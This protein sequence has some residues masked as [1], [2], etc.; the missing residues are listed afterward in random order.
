[1]IRVRCDRISDTCGFGVPLYRFEGHRPQ[2]T[3]WAA[4]KGAKALAEYQR[5][6]NAASL[7]GLP[8]VSTEAAPGAEAQE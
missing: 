4:R 2:L 5:Q 7:D 1:M 3:D 6:K 8:G